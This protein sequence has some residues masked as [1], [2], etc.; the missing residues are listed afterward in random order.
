VLPY[1]DRSAWMAPYRVGVQHRPARRIGDVHQAHD[2]LDE[3]LDIGG[4]DPDGEPV[5]DRAG[6]AD[7]ARGGRGQPELSLLVPAHDR[8]VG[9]DVPLDAHDQRQDDRQD[10]ACVPARWPIVVISAFRSANL[11]LPAKGRS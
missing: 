2:L 1:R 9:G 8:V 6:L 3:A 5:D 4:E 10:A 7:R 11:P